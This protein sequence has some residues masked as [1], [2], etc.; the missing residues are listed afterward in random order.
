MTALSMIVTK[1]GRA[2]LVNAEH[3]GTAK[4]QIAEIGITATSFVPG[5]DMTALPGEIKRIATI[6]GEVVA[7]DT[8]HVTIRDD[9]PDVYTV[10]GIGY[11]LSNGVLFAVY[12]QLDPILQKSAQAM[13][14]LSADTVFTSIKVTSLTFGDASF[15]NPPASTERQ[16]VVELAT[17]LE[18]QAGKDASRAVTPAGLS[19]TIAQAIS[20]H[21]AD[22]DP[23]A[24]YVKRSGDSMGPLSSAADKPNISYTGPG[25]EVRE[26]GRVANTKGNDISYAPKLVFN[27]ESTTAVQLRM[28]DKGTLELVD[29]SGTAH[30]TFQSGTINA[31]QALTVAGQTVW[32]G[33]NFNPADKVNGSGIRLNWSGYGGQPNW[34]FGGNSSDNVV[35]YNPS[36]FNVNYANSANYASTAGN[37][38]ALSGV[39]LRFA[40]NG[41][42]QPYYLWGTYV[43]DGRVNE[44]T[45]FTRSNLAV[46]SAVSAIYASQLTGQGL[47]DGGVG[48]YWLNKNHTTSERAGA[49]QSR[50]SAYEY[51]SG[52][53]GN[54]GTRV[55]L[56]Q[57]VA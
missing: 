40:D 22:A 21:K 43:G 52:T 7:P 37:A 29:G 10:R 14:L 17:V 13:L 28:T 9:G 25:L 50:G 16:G 1:A 33:G 3:N 12:G 20:T 26:A 49:W 56:W 51:G 44:F 35:V 8:L 45:L 32:H 48:S 42:A 27:W 23:H 46:G 38:N 30:G 5:E 36:N 47:Q 54:I 39:P 19:A 18:A 57:R 34:V 24:A 2:A 41:A 55:A 11:W 4:L 6:A 31:T 53:D 15:T